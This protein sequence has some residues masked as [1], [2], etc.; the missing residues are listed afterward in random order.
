MTPSD[1]A[2]IRLS[3][4][5]DWQEL[6]NFDSQKLLKEIE[7]FKDDWKPYNPK[8]PN[9]RWGLSVTSIDG[10][11]SGIP[12]LNSLLD[13]EKE[14]G[15]V[16]ENIDL[17]VPTEVYKQNEELQKILKPYLPWL[18]RCHF[19]RIDRG[20]FFPDHLD[21][22]QAERYGFDEVRLVGFVHVNEYGFKWIYDDRIIKKN[23]GTLWYFN[24]GK[25]HNVFSTD[26]GMILLIICLSPWDEKLFSTIFDQAKV[27]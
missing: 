26:D 3:M 11:L 16:V 2:L 23:N 24:G 19:L 12:D 15:Q 7:Q 17:N 1:K 18:T 9:N 22:I 20:G 14:T 5:S 27:N 13:Y 25:R 4:M 6:K 10:K 8:K 21:V